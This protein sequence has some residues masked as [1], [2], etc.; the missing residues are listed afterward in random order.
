[1]PVS[2]EDFYYKQTGAMNEWMNE[3]SVDH[4]QIALNSNTLFIKYSS[5]N[6]C[7]KKKWIH[8]K[9]CIQINK[10]KTRDIIM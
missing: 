3:K 2:P 1:M 8:T 9:C 7:T 4:S 6:E 5:T 10:Y